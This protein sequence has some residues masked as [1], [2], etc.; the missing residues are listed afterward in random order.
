M[1]ILQ[2]INTAISLIIINNSLRDDGIIPGFLDTTGLDRVLFNGD[3]SDFTTEWYDVVG[4]TIFTTAFI[5]G[6]APVVNIGW[7]LKALCTRCCDRG[8]TCNV[9]KTRKPLQ[10]EYV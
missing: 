6:V 7:Y 4:I 1:W 8:C 10:N 2:Y 9:K 5:N 3:Y